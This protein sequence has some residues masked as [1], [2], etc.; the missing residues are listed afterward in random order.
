MQIDD[1][2]VIL[3]SQSSIL[4][5]PNTSIFAA[6]GNFSIR[7]ISAAA[8]NS[9]FTSI[10][11][12][13]SSRIKPVCLLYIGFR[14]RDTACL[15]PSFFAKS[16]DTILISSDSDEAMKISARAQPASDSTS[17][18]IPLPQIPITS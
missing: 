3:T 4:P 11:M 15:A 12:P 13:I 2:P 8:S 16:A 5:L 7:E 17:M 9:G 10:L 6:A 14:T 18:L 1:S